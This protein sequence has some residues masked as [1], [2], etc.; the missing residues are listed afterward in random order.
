M[1]SSTLV[2]PSPTHSFQLT[3]DQEQLR[4]TIRK[5]AAREI[6]PHVMEWDEASEFPIKVVKQLGAPASAMSTT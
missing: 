4:Q 3:E 2:A 6:A 5:F 1:A